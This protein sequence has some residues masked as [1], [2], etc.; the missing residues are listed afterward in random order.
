MFT[1]IIE[2]GFTASHQLTRLDGEKELI[3]SHNW[4]VIAEVGSEKL[5]NMGLVMDFRRLKSFLD[6]ILEPFENRQL[7]EFE[8]FQKNSSSAENVAEYVHKNLKSMLSDRVR[9]ESVTVVEE[10]GCSAK[11]SD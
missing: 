1:V 5:N 3:H 2:T 11:F 10:L 6:K 4:R 8:V 7:E 9:L